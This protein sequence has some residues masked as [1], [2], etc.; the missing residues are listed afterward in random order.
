MKEREGMQ[1]HRRTGRMASVIC[2]SLCATALLGCGSAS[3]P[4]PAATNTLRVGISTLSASLDSQVACDLVSW[5]AL[6]M[7]NDPLV[8]VSDDG[9]SVEP[10]LATSWNR[11]D[12]KTWTIKLRTGVKF[13]DGE[14]FDAEAVK[15]TLERIQ[16]DTACLKSTFEFIDKV[17]AVDASTVRVTT[18]D[19]RWDTMILLGY[20]DVLPPKA[21]EEKSFGTKPIGTGPYKVEDWRPNNQL[22]LVRND[23]YWA[24][25]PR[26]DRVTWRVM[27]EPSARVDA[28]LTKEVD[29]INAVPVEQIPSLEDAGLKVK[30]AP[31]SR[32]ISV[33]V[34]IAKKSPLSD[35]PKV[36]EA[37]KYAVNRDA[38]AENLLG[39][40][41]EAADS[42]VIY[43][44]LKYAAT[45]DPPYTY[46]PAKAKRLLAEAGH[47]NGIKGCLFGAPIG[48]HV[49]DQEVGAAVA[50]D[51]KA[52]GIDCK[53]EQGDI[54]SFLAEARK[55]AD[56]KYDLTFL[57][58][59]PASFGI[60]YGLQILYSS[61]YIDWRNEKFRTALRTAGAAGSD[62]A[63]ERLYEE[64][65]RLAF[66][67]G[68][69]AHLYFSPTV[70]A[71]TDDVPIEP[72]LDE[73]ILLG[74][75]F[76][77]P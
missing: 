64:A 69:Y 14:P 62:D 30:S 44:K 15:Y 72:R 4:E 68:P 38:L 71:M 10:W 61:A 70:M 12:A 20:P 54:S 65:Q 56:S 28:L 3:E 5:G 11:D 17:E 51:L 41:A 34:N 47:P 9:T 45:F 66:E 73:Y 6:R 19:P 63:R 55:G 76:D 2:A 48:A 67:Q 23:A 43:P 13:H 7:I 58:L 52:V 75:R 16:R 1:Q 27:P 33:A 31:T 74:D 59:A 50:G 40:L 39:G 57:S 53:L 22:T 60:Q 8:N 21:A 36:I 37:I 18:T 29:M 35:N 42:S 25:K 32:P 49:K 77:A 24:A 26:Y 46:D